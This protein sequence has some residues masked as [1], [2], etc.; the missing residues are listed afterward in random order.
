MRVL[1]KT[2]VAWE[3]LTTPEQ[4]QIFDLSDQH[5]TVGLDDVFE[6]RWLT[7]VSVAFSHIE[8]SHLFGN[9]VAFWTFPNMHAHGIRPL[10]YGLLILGS[11]MLGNSAFLQV[12][13]QESV[14]WLLTPTPYTRGL[15]LSDVAMG[16][17]VVTLLAAP[18]ASILSPGAFR[19]P[20]YMA[21]ILY[22]A[23]S[24]MPLEDP[25]STLGHATHLGGAVFGAFFCLLRGRNAAL[26]LEG[27]LEK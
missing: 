3:Y 1:S 19:T 24:S 21:M 9:L 4:R 20:V 22:V 17:G 12:A 18:T 10:D 6:E 14:W 8:I 13:Q 23:C 26:P 7:L 2:N 5:F 27:L 25:T 11:A 15:G 16:L